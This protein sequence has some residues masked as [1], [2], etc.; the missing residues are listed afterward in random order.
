MKKAI[1]FCR[2]KWK[3][4]TLHTF[5][6][7]LDIVLKSIFVV[8]YSINEMDLFIIFVDLFISYLNSRM[9]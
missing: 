6:F 1:S 7:W 9:C 3:D 5:R 8:D 2:G 4:L